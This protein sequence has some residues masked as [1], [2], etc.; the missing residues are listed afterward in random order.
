MLYVVLLLVA[1]TE[2]LALKA[3]VTDLRALRDDVARILTD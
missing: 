1:H 2:A 3:A